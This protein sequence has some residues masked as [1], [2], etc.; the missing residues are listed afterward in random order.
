[1]IRHKILSI[2]LLL[3]ICS[4]FGDET[5]HFEIDPPIQ[6]ERSVMIN[7]QDVSILEFIRFV[8]KIAAVN[9]IYDELV[10]PIII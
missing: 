2:F 10:V 8:S 6:E 1:M 4:L 3:G 7:F 9:F 5:I